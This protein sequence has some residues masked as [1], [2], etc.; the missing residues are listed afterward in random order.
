[1]IS[2]E[3]MSK[4]LFIHVSLLLVVMANV[5]FIDLILSFNKALSAF[6]VISLPLGVVMLPFNLTLTGI[7]SSFKHLS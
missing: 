7:R 3:K 2:L 6:L 5:L 1:M 4:R